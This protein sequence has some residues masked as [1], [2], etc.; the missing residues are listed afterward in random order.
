[1]ALDFSQRS[2]L[3]SN[4]QVSINDSPWTIIVSIPK[5]FIYYLDTK[6]NTTKLTPLNRGII[7]TT[8][9]QASVPFYICYN[10]ALDV[11]LL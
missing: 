8:R 1:M 2:S 3:G 10:G 11:F 7:P 6:R 4:G 5:T 9:R